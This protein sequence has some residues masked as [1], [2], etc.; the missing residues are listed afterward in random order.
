MVVV[1]DL[2]ELAAAFTRHHDVFGRL[3]ICINSAG[4]ITGAQPF[5]EHEEAWRKVIDVNLVAVINGTC[6]AVNLSSHFRFMRGLYRPS[7]SALK[8]SFV[9]TS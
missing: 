6:K 2:D 1:C 7:F 5:H 4:V 3:H 9:W 8:F